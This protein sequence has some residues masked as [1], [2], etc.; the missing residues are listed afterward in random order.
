MMFGRLSVWRAFAATHVADS[1][2][3]RTYLF[4][5][6]ALPEW[7][8]F[9]F[10][11]G[12]AT[13]LLTGTAQK[14]A[15]NILAIAICLYILQGLAVFR[16]MLVRAGAGYVGGTLGFFLLIMLCLTGIGLALL[17]AVGLFDPF[18]DF[19]HLNRKDDSHEGHTD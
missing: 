1:E 3:R 13:P 19:R 10:V 4:R 15:A 16:S 17:A 6:L 7:L 18:L 2:T 5:N 12:G 9:L 14:V 8:L 11:A